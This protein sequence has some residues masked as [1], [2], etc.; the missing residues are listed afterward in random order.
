MFKEGGYNQNQKEIRQEVDQTKKE[1]EKLTSIFL[2]KRTVFLGVLSAAVVLVLS[3]DREEQESV[4]T[5]ER[6]KEELRINDE[7]LPKDEEQLREAISAAEFLSKLLRERS[8]NVVAEN[9]RNEDED[10]ETQPLA[11]GLQVRR[12]VGLDGQE[13]YFIEDPLKP[14]FQTTTEKNYL[15]LIK[16]F[17][18]H[19]QDFKIQR[20]DE[21]DYVVNLKDYA[22]FEKVGPFDIK[23]R[24]EEDGSYTVYPPSNFGRQISVSNK[25]NL[26]EVIL[27]MVELEKLEEKWA[28]GKIDDRE[29]MKKARE[30]FGEL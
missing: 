14:E 25:E 11:G 12:V 10:W 6:I 3:R 24:A 1:K 8:K 28:Q 2:N 4:E 22:D 23:I 20:L 27:I 17:N 30:L 9:L 21:T 5:R 13:R 18:Q 15:E 26:A 19:L 29:F 16:Y 7:D